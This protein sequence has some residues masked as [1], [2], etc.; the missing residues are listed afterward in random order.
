MNTLLGVI[1]VALV[2]GWLLLVE[3]YFK[4]EGVFVF[5]AVASI[6]AN[7]LICKSITVLGLSATLGNVLF[8]SNF[9]A[10]DILSEK[11]G[12]EHSR[13]ATKMA[14]MAVLM[15]VGATQMALLFIPNEYDIANAAMQTLFTLSLRTSLVS[16]T[17]F[18]LSNMVDIFLFEAIKEKVPNK[19][20]LRNNV[21]TITANCTENFLFYG[22]A[23]YGIMDWKTIFSCALTATIIEF[24]IAI[25]DT[26]FLYIATKEKRGSE[27]LSE[28]SC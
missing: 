11:Y 1:A 12:V 6:T 26:P 13:K 28:V 17:L 14:V 27:K 22:I 7:I 8:A 3:R 21:A 4:K 9:L 5:M 25:C 10:T 18:F 2:F 23:F 24:I 16:I 15:F 20:W 19:L